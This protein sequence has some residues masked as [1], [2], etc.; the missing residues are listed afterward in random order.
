SGS[1]SDV[2]FK[3][4]LLRP[5]NRV[6]WYEHLKASWDSDYQRVHSDYKIDGPK[7]KFWLLNGGF[8]INFDGSIDP[9]LPQHIQLTRALMLGGI[10]QLMKSSDKLGLVDLQST[11]DSY[12]S[13][14]YKSLSS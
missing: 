9:I 7:G 6:Q 5:E 8:P 3:E 1:T 14:V 13:K 12:I 2:E 4:I 10:C 11:Y